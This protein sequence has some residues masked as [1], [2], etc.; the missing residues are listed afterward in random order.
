MIVEKMNDGALFVS[1]S[2]YLLLSI[3]INMINQSFKMNIAL[4]KM[5]NGIKWILVD[6]FANMFLL[7]LCLCFSGFHKFAIN[8]ILEIN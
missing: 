2:L 5:E 6:E 8:I 4:N 1:G 7:I 3:N